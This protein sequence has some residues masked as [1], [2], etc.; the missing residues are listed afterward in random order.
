MCVCVCFVVLCGGEASR[1]L[2]RGIQS[3]HG[4]V[5][6]SGA[7]PEPRDRGK[8]R[9]NTYLASRMPT[10][11]LYQP[12]LMTAPMPSSSTPGRNPLAG[13]LRW[14]MKKNELAILPVDE[15][16]CTQSSR[17]LPETRNWPI[18][19]PCLPLRVVVV[20]VCNP[21]ISPVGDLTMPSP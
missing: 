10:M 6:C 11:S 15:T 5:W 14:K 2:Q 18:P 16:I 3:R 17:L 4:R 13:R 21:F 20:P 9:K 19:K 8:N 12:K 1:A 7:R